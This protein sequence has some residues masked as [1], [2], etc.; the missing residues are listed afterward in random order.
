VSPDDQATFGSLVDAAMAKVDAGGHGDADSSPAD[1]GATLTAELD[2][3]TET[4][5]AANPLALT[6]MLTSQQAPVVDTSLAI[7]GGPMIEDVAD[8][9]TVPPAGLHSAPSGAATDAPANIAAPVATDASDLA[10]VVTTPPAGGSRSQAPDEVLAA[11]SP[12]QDAQP[13]PVGSRLVDRVA[14]GTAS[15][16]ARA[17]EP[18]PVTPPAASVPDSTPPPAASPAVAPL[19]P[20]ATP[21]GA[22]AADATASPPAAGTTTGAAPDITEPAPWSQI[23]HAVRSVQRDRDGSHTMTVRLDPP[24]L[25]SVDIEVRVHDGRLSVHATVDSAATRDL[26]TRAL[27]ELRSALESHGLPT[28]SLDVGAR[29]GSHGHADQDRTG[30]GDARP[31]GDDAA[32]RRAIGDDSPH[33]RVDHAG[34]GRVDLRL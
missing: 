3:G 12:D 31:S 8:A 28:A 13:Q 11:P 25:G 23:A 15:D 9:G 22:T 5:P 7:A 14:D 24:E 16:A 33:P 27:P 29:S 18:L 30:G 21:P 2:V 32:T 34:A 4:P 19:V 6:L 1:D 10:D 20:G 17:D 26:L